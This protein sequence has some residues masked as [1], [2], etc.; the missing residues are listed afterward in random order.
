MV[1]YTPPLASRP[2]LERVG[3]RLKKF[4]FGGALVCRIIF[5]EKYFEKF[6]NTYEAHWFIVNDIEWLRRDASVFVSCVIGA[7]DSSYYSGIVSFGLGAGITAS[8][9]L[10][11][12]VLLLSNFTSPTVR[13]RQRHCYYS[14]PVAPQNLSGLKQCSCSG[15]RKALMPFVS[16]WLHRYSWCCT[17]HFAVLWVA[18]DG[19]QLSCLGFFEGDHRCTECTGKREQ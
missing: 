2:P 7:L 12:N 3:C 15:L 6:T 16:C 8:Y 13:K 9:S 19:F 1:A 14:S 4:F 18:S 11:S 10:L 5:V 17:I